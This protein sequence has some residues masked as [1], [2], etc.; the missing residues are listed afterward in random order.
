MNK[1]GNAEEFSA[2]C[3]NGG[4]GVFTSGRWD[5]IPVIVAVS[6]LLY[7]LWARTSL[8]GLV[9]CT[10]GIRPYFALSRFVM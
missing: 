10:N 1:G 3:V 2:G 4:E 6:V 5:D 8:S 7:L 9:L